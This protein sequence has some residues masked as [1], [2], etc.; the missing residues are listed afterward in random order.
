MPA[1]IPLA[2]AYL[3]VRQPAMQPAAQKKNGDDCQVIAI[4]FILSCC[5]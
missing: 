1:I 3:L 5:L 2:A 4:V